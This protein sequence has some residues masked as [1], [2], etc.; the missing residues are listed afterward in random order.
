MHFQVDYAKAGLVLRGVHFAHYI[1]M[2]HDTATMYGLQKEKGARVWRM[3]EH[4]IPKADLH[5]GRNLTILDTA[6]GNM[7]LVGQVASYELTRFENKRPVEGMVM[8]L[9]HI[10]TALS[11]IMLPSGGWARSEKFQKKR[12]KQGSALQQP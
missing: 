11:S 10:W 8:L 3:F 9:L 1:L 12:A 7:T 5:S 2:Q 4:Q 6:S